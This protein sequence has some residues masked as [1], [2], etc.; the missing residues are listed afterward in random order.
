MASAA[1]QGMPSSAARGAHISG[2]RLFVLPVSV[3]VSGHGWAEDG[4]RFP[5]TGEEREGEGEGE[6]GRRTARIVLQGGSSFP[7]PIRCAARGSFGSA[8]DS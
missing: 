4:A 6:K 2:L 3:W 1:R 8:A 5:R 7:R